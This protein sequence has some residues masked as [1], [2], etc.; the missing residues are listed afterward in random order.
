MSDSEQ[1]ASGS[2]AGQARPASELSQGVASP[3]CWLCLLACAPGSRRPQDRWPQ[4]GQ[5]PARISSPSPR[6]SWFLF[7][8]RNS[9]VVAA[10]LAA[11]MLG[12]GLGIPVLIEKVDLT[13][14]ASRPTAVYPP[15]MGCFSERGKVCGGRSCTLMLA[16]A[17]DPFPAGPLPP[18][19]TPGLPLP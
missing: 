1:M 2:Q 5:L 3:G 13:R 10:A 8:T 16:G 15:R 6:P 12:A 14:H 11:M 19:P 7:L 17:P 4:L 9:A 18:T